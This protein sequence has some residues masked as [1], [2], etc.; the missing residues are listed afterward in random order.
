VIIA[1]KQLEE[2]LTRVQKPARYTGGEW[3]SIVRDW[4]AIA[5]SASGAPVTLALAYPDVYDIGMSNLGLTI[6]YGL[7]NAQPHMLAERVYAP[8]PDMEAAL[9]E[10]GLPLFSLETRHS[11]DSFDVIGFTLPYE[12]NYSNA[13][14]MLDLA[15]LP[16]LAAERR[17]GMPLVIAGGSCALN[18]EPMA[19]FFDALVLG[20]GEDVLLE[21]LE[22]VAS[23]KRA[24]ADER[25]LVDE[26]SADSGRQGLL[27]RLAQ[28]P[29]VYVPS[30]YKV[31]YSAEGWIEGIKPVDDAIPA[32]VRRRIVPALGPAPT[33]PT[34]PGMSTVHD[35]G[36]VEIQRGCSRGCRFC[37]AGII[38]RP[39]RERPAA[40]VLAAID[41]LVANTGYDE[42]GL[43]SL[44]SSDH[45]EIAAIVEQAMASHADDRLS[46]SLP[47][48]RIDS[49]SVELAEMIQSARKTGFTFAPEAGSQRLRD[50]INK[51]VTEEDLL[52]TARA[53]FESGWNRI[54]LYFMIGLPTETDEDVLEIARL[55]G[56]LSDL[57]KRIRGR[58]VDLSV[59]VST[60]VPK[61][62]TP[63]QW[64][65][66]AQRETIQRRQNLLKAHC[67]QRG[68][69]LSWSDWDTTWLEALLSRGDRRLAS[70]IRRAWELGARFDAWSDQFRP[71]LW[72][73]ALEEG[74]EAGAVIDPDL[75][76]FRAYEEGIGVDQPLPWDVVDVG[77]SRKFL[78][79]EY[80]RALAGELS[81]DCR[82]QCHGCGIMTS[83]GDERALVPEDVWECP[84]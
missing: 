65:P 59:S 58:I 84:A 8:W 71:E 41:A 31:T 53:A 7:V 77:V 60:F 75:Y 78:W 3:N 28:I 42:V 70:V 4:D 45:S 52:E 79:R 51:G 11:L 72:R 14:T 46:I 13:L 5:H 18:P 27:H 44:S 35:R 74:D 39:V 33:S 62:H 21:L 12:L 15:G 9:R 50:V 66:L 48:L 30:L 6:L 69:H 26:G 1:Y 40:E 36:A 49:F 47:S 32:Q 56:A 73:Q 83:Y 67:R 64:A 37:Q 19:P 25:A 22:V 38:Y 17:A 34:L 54:K 2:L 23:W 82:R 24:L 80:Q 55:V 10:A 43:L 16:L 20:D 63:F 68:V 61:P 76:T 29:G 57:G 81:P